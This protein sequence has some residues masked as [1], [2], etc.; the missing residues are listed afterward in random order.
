MLRV[1]LSNLR[2][3]K[4]TFIG[5]GGIICVSGFKSW[6]N[7]NVES[8]NTSN[9]HINYWRK[10]SEKVIDVNSVPSRKKQLFELQRRCR[11]STEHYSS[12]VALPDE[13]EASDVKPEYD[14]LVIGGGATG[15]GIALDAV[16]RG[17]SVA[18]VEGNDFASG[19]SSRS[20]KL[21]HGG[22]RYLENAIT[23]LDV[24]AYKLV[25]EAILERRHLIN[26]TP[27]LSFALPIII[28]VYD[29]YFLR[30]CFSLVKH[31]I[32]LKIYEAMA[33]RD[34]L[35]CP[36][37]YLS[38]PHARQLFPHLKQPD[39]CGTIVYFDGLHNDSRMCLNIALTAA[40]YGANV[41]NYVKVVDFIKEN[42]PSVDDYAQQKI[43]G[44]RLRDS[45]TGNEWNTFAKVV[46]NATGCSVD[47]V[48]AL[49]NSKLTHSDD[50]IKPSRG[51]HI[52]LP[53]SFSSQNYGMLIPKTKDGRVAFLLPFEGVTVAGTTDVPIEH[54]QIPYDERVQLIEPKQD[55][56]EMIIDE[57]NQYLDVPVS[58]SDVDA[59]WS[60]IRPLSVIPS[61][62]VHKVI[63]GTNPI[64]YIQ[65]PENNPASATTTASTT[66]TS[67]GRSTAEISRHHLIELSNSGLV[68]ICGGKWTTY[69]AMAEDVVDVVREL[70]PEIGRR[71]TDCV[72]KVV[73]LIGSAD[74]THSVTA[75]LERH[76]IPAETAEH[77]SK[78]YGDKSFIVG[79]LFLSKWSKLLAG[80]Y[81]YCMAEVVYASEHEMAQTPIDVLSRRTRLAQLNKAAAEYALPMVINIMGEVHDWNV[82]KRVAHYHDSM[83]FL[84]TMHVKDRHKWGRS[85]HTLN[86]ARRV[87]ETV[88][89]GPSMTDEAIQFV[90]DRFWDYYN[91][92]NAEA[93]A[94]SNSSTGNSHNDGDVD[95]EQD[96]K[97]FHQQSRQLFEGCISRAQCLSL[98]YEF[99]NVFGDDRVIDALMFTGQQQ[100]GLYEILVSCA[101]CAS[102]RELFESNYY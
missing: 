94:G 65:Q 67:N 30:G 88:L 53:A 20:T 48:R 6:S 7:R 73:K 45:L 24:D 31:Y 18:L 41:A 96:N 85:R 15:T 77:L 61:D 9:P 80:G 75:I 82:R 60:G 54:E 10:Q 79:N 52:V 89:N 78:N 33:G 17:L 23:K 14:V 27:H 68:T 49:D 71:S 5:C 62:Y 101:A 91:A 86:Y 25:K 35:L 8:I 36:T 56:V 1:V 32:G 97:K 42:N 72:T 40:N 22:V 13:I 95:A 12:V 81:P 70:H 55:E 26:L 3:Y 19:T 74:W 93:D 83:E 46:V 43:I 44:V 47:R 90:I 4:L 28:P 66:N 21:I 92:N 99:S 64:N 100:L 84:R 87:V 34:G 37:Y 39:L 63:H 2:K 69:R 50:L 98:A 51:T 11:S 102:H 58:Q 59:V 76:Q 38:S 57:L 16:T 29:E